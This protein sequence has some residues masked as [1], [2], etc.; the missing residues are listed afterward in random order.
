MKFYFDHLFGQQ[1]DKDFIYSLISAEF[2]PSEWNY[3]FENGW[4]PTHEYYISDFSNKLLWYQSRQTRINIEKYTPSRK[5]RKLIKDTPIEYKITTEVSDIHSVYEIYLQYCE[6]KNFGDLA[7]YSYIKKYFTSAQPGYYIQFF[8]QNQLIAI[9]KISVWDTNPIAEFFWW[10]YN[11]PSLSVGRLSS[12]LEL[13]F[14][15]SKGYN[16]LYVGL[17]YNAESKYKSL[18]KGFQWWTGRYWS[19]NVDQFLFLCENDD[20]INTIQDLYEFQI[21]YLNEI[22]SENLNGTK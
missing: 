15:K 7:D 8:Y 5:T 11:T 13:D 6:Y 9:T 4:A 10:N 17:A 3:A 19:E 18:K 12:Y 22:K 2:E 1:T 16:F 14:A 21:K 20:K